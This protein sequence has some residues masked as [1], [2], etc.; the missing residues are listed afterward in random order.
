MRGYAN[1]TRSRNANNRCKL[2]AFLDGN[3][4]NE[5]LF[6]TRPDEFEWREKQCETVAARVAQ[7]T[8]LKGPRG[9]VKMVHS[10]TCRG[11]QMRV[12]IGG[13]KCLEGCERM[14]ISDVRG[15]SFQCGI[16]PCSDSVNLVS[17][18][19]DECKKLVNIS[20]R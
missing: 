12:E 15:E 10:V 7:T 14:W 6:A 5:T 8:K 13:W 3:D 11:A 9:G 20:G 2:T 4:G 19:C 17:G 1:S 16:F 18:N